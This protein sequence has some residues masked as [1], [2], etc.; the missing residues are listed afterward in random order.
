[1]RRMRG[2]FARSLVLWTLLMLLLAVLLTA[3]ALGSL[4][5]EGQTCFFNSSV[6]C[7]SGD[8]AAVA[9]LTFAFFGV[10]LVWLVGIALAVLGQAVFR[11][12]RAD[13]A[14]D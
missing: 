10:P 4:I 8:D 11:R 14:R 9:R 2:R 6:S 1:M 7:P 12:Q 3:Q 5:G 13:P